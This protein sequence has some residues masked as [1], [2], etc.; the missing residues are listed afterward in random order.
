MPV[1]SAER[2]GTFS[3]RVKEHLSS[4]RSSRIFKHLENRPFYSCL[5]GELAFEWQRARL[6]VTLI[7]FIQTSPLLLSC[8]CI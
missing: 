7:V 1:T 3:T 4:T 2:S 8:K 5:L 6:E